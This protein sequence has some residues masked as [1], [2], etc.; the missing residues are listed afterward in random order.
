MQLK[1]NIQGNNQAASAK[2]LETFQY[3]L[4]DSSEAVALIAETLRKSYKYPIKTSVQ[5]YLSNARDVHREC[6]IKKPIDVQIPT[7]LNSEFFIRDY[8]TGL[9]KEQMQDYITFAKSTKRQS[10]TATGGFGF[11]SKSFFSYADSFTIISFY[12]GV[13]YIY[14][15]SCV[16]SK[17]G[18]LTLVSQSATNE[19]SGLQVQVA[20]R[21]SDREEFRKAVFRL[22]LHWLDQEINII[23]LNKDEYPKSPEVIFS[24]N[25]L[26]VWQNMSKSNN[27]QYRSSYLG[28]YNLSN[29]V[30]LLVDGIPY[31]LDNFEFDNQSVAKFFSKFNAAYSISISV[32]TGELTLSK[33]REYIESTPENKIIIEKM[34]VNMVKDFEAGQLRKFGKMSIS[35]LSEVTPEKLAPYLMVS[36]STTADFKVRNQV[37][38]LLIEQDPY[39]R[40]YFSKYSL[41]INVNN[42]M[43]KIGSATLSRHRDKICCDRSERSLGFEL[44]RSDRVILDPQEPGENTLY[45]YSVGE[46]QESINS[47]LKSLYLQ[48]SSHRLQVGLLLF[49][50]EPTEQDY[51]FLEIVGYTTNLN[52]IEKF[53]SKPKVVKKVKKKI[54]DANVVQYHYLICVKSDDGR[55]TKIIKHQ[56]RSSALLNKLA[57]QITVLVKESEPFD[58]VCSKLMKIKSLQLQTKW[59]INYIIVDKENYQK[60]INKPNSYCFSTFSFEKNKHSKA[61]QEMITRKLTELV[62]S[63][64]KECDIF[65]QLSL[66]SRT[67]ILPES[68]KKLVKEI[69]KY[70][71]VS[72]KIS[73]NEIK[74]AGLLDEY[75]KI[76][77]NHK[78]YKLVEKYQYLLLLNPISPSWNSNT[79]QGKWLK[80]ILYK[81]K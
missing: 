43:F 9:S 65:K 17:E 62:E 5:E 81:F 55:K 20:V 19:P 52:T 24:E 78:S 29:Q 14:R 44:L 73:E 25:T 59:G 72:Y 36:N 27:Q 10:N 71:P 6:N 66:L 58:K 37:Y 26:Q 15:A 56:R 63:Q 69:E 31:G 64:V 28:K 39:N 47:R 74:K 54:N 23:N 34:L 70:K 50:R 1:V 61:V 7:E 60:L 57:K 80:Q 77:N 76:N 42:F 30:F 38:E 46:N 8:G 12:Q 79:E 32:N 68:E 13:K 11:G 48:K 16:R 51:A 35:S 49:T 18:A 75:D 45:Y 40:K 53:K 22:K 67:N 33:Y 4:D 21:Q 3:R 2:P 41:L